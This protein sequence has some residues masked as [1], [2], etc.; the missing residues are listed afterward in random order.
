MAG[1]ADFNSEEWSLLARSPFM[2]G[3]IVS[4]ASPS[5]I[6]GV[7]S[8][9]LVVTRAV[10]AATQSQPEHSL[11]RE[12]VDDIKGSRGEIAKAQG[13][14]PANA[15][16][17]ARET[18]QQVSA[19]LAQKAT[20]EEAAAFKGWLKDIARQSAEAAKEGGFFGIGGVQ[21]SETEKAA[22][23]EVDQLLS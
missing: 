18:L 16:T 4:M 21:I 23:A 14:T 22:L 10:L 8:E 6:T 19:L 3:L 11:L 5:G 7:V 2:T 12:L 1:K 15:K 13:L 20:P 17:V 9:S